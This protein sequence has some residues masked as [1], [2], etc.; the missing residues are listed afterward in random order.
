YHFCHKYYWRANDLIP[1]FVFLNFADMDYL[2]HLKQKDYCK[3]LLQ[4]IS[5]LIDLRFADLVLF[6]VIK[7]E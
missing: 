6:E 1:G 2:L 4:E 5:D 3:N 7:P